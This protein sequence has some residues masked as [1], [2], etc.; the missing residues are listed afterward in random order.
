[1]ADNC[2]QVRNVGDY[3]TNDPTRWS[4]D[5][6]GAGVMGPLLAQSPLSVAWWCNCLGVLTTCLIMAVAIYASDWEQLSK[7]A[8]AELIEDEKVAAS[9]TE[10]RTSEEERAVANW[11]RSTM[12]DVLLSGPK[13]MGRTFSGKERDTLE[14]GEHWVGSVADDN[15]DD[16]VDVDLTWPRS[17]RHANSGSA[18]RQT[19]PNRNG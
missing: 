4:C 13:L 9:D 19:A 16:G 2:F 6:D 11:T 5:E 17:N 18:F 15:H 1:M 14:S 10:S 8:Q 12:E 7:D 3:D